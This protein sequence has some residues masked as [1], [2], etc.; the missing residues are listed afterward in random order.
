MTVIVRGKNMSLVLFKISNV[1]RDL[2]AKSWNQ[3]APYWNNRAD[4]YLTNKILLGM[5]RNR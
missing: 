5:W 3:G 1:C 2:P 4:L